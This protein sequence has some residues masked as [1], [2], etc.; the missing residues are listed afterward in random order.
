MGV[1]Y[2]NKKGAV[3]M[4][5]KTLN[6][7]V[8]K[9]GLTVTENHAF[10]IYG[11]YLLTVYEAG[12]KKTAFFNFILDDDTEE[13]ENVQERSNE[14]SVAAFEISEAIKKNIDKFSIID[15][16]FMDDGLL[17]TT[18]QSIQVFLELIDFCTELLREHKIKGGDYC[19]NCGKTFGKR[20]PKKITL[21]NRNYLYCESCAFDIYEEHNKPDALK[22]EAK[23][24]GKSF[25][26]FLG[27][28]AGGLL[29]AFLYFAIYMWVLPGS[30]ALEDFDWRFL[31]IILGFI[32]SFLVFTGY[33][34]F[35][36]KANTFAFVTV[37]LLSAILTAVGQ[38][39]GTLVNIAR[40]FSLDFDSF[41]IYKNWFLM[42]FR[43]TVPEDS[44]EYTDLVFNTDFYRFAIIGVA[45]A[46]LGSVI[47]LLG[48][49]EK[50]RPVKEEMFLETLKIQNVADKK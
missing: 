28:L 36:K 49:Y 32:T 39:I 11:G 40:N 12:N 25:F 20:F 7:A 46:L 38:Y 42:P 10:G 41:F 43:N 26:G 14:S 22:T 13:D 27:A 45:L 37:T 21:G 8:S 9:M 4:L 1:F 18:N 2:S 6:A 5:S 19:S 44:T 15:Y 48:F 29:G 3:K 23:S 17:V 31:V 34:I 33:K 47:F 50:S 30:E 16:I 35:C 24:G